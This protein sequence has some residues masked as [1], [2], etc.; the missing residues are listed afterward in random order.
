LSVYTIGDCDGLG[1]SL[2][3]AEADGLIDRLSDADPEERLNEDDGLR[4][5]EEDDDS[6]ALGL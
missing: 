2:S 4:E 6:E 1:L 5:A 3:L